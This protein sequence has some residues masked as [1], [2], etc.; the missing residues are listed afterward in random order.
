M[1][2]ITTMHCDWPAATALTQ[3]CSTVLPAAQRYIYIA[4]I[5]ACVLYGKQQHIVSSL[6]LHMYTP[7][8]L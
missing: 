8:S 3:D 2:F 5:D 1:L 4:P 6:V 7:C